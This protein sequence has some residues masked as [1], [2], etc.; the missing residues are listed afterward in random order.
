[1]SWPEFFTWG[2]WVH[3]VVGGAHFSSALVALV[4]GPVIFLK[5]KATRFHRVAGYVFVLA[6]LTVNITALT[7]YELS[8]WPNLFHVFAV[9]S[10][11]ALI[12]AFWALQQGVRRKD[13]RLLELHARLMMWAYF[14]LAAAGL[15]QVG[16]RILPAMLGSFTQ[17]FVVIGV[18]LGTAGLLCTLLFRIT[19]RRL[20]ER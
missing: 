6:M 13:D 7:L 17:T 12:P 15:A 11:T 20:T 1:M 18:G 14:G 10:L 4:L 3:T 8:G 16:T 2:F 19:S 9:W 5:R